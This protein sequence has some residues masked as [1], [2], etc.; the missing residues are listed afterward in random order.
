MN[1]RPSAEMLA[2]MAAQARDRAKAAPAPKSPEE[3]AKSAGPSVIRL[4]TADVRAWDGNPRNQVNPLKPEI[5]ESIDRKSTRLNS[6][7]FH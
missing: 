4:R 6:S 2:K 5:K 7:H 3:A 1:R